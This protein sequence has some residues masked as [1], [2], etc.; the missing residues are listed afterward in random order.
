MTNTL[1]PDIVKPKKRTPTPSVLAHNAAAKAARAAAKAPAKRGRPPGPPKVAAPKPS[2][3]VFGRPTSYDPSYCQKA[4]ELGEQGKSPVQ[5][6]AHFNVPRQTLHSWRQAHAE[7]AEAMVLAHD[8]AQAFWENVGAVGAQTKTVDNAIWS[9]IMAQRFK[10][11]WREVKA[12]EHSGQIDT[13]RSSIVED[14]LGLVAK[15]RVKDLI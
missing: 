10:E 3:Y 14:I 12:V 8:K 15:S 4:V 1:V 6:A 9:R 7:F 11:D 5:I 2:G 13:G